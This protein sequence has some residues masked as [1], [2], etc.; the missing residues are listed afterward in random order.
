MPNHQKRALPSPHL[1]ARLSHA[2]SPKASLLSEIRKSAI[3]NFSIDTQFTHIKA[4]W[5]F[6]QPLTYLTE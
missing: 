3:A 4:D 5:R 2:Q 6:H 1:K